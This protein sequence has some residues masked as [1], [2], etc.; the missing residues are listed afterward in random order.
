LPPQSAFTP[1]PVHEHC[2]RLLGNACPCLVGHQRPLVPHANGEAPLLLVRSQVPPYPNPLMSTEG[3]LPSSLR[4]L[5]PPCPADDARLAATVSCVELALFPAFDLSDR[6]LGTLA[7]LLG[8]ASSDAAA[9]ITCYRSD[10]KMRSEGVRSAA[11]ELVGDVKRIAASALRDRIRNVPPEQV[12]ELDSTS[13][14]A[15]S[16]CHPSTGER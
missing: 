11:L 16:G 3:D 12:G 13:G 8:I 1:C 15:R 6:H 5:A 7:R 14:T 9:L 2:A 4:L 10:A